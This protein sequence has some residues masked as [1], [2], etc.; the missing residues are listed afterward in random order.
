MFDGVAEDAMNFYL[1]LFKESKILSITRYGPN[2]PG[3]EGTVKRAN[4]LL[5]NQEFMCTDSNVK[6]DF[7]FTLAMSTL[8]EL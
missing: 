8:R 4:F 5:D 2:E 3:A 7:T 1:S 6:H